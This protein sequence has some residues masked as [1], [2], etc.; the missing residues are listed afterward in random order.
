MMP[1]SAKA[2]TGIQMKLSFHQITDTIAELLA[3]VTHTTARSS[4]DL[5]VLYSP[6]VP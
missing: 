3:T 2:V 5:V 1:I 4:R 6:R